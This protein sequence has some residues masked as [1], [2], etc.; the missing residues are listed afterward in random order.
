MIRISASLILLLALAVVHHTQADAGE[1][2]T[3]DVSKEL[4]SKMKFN[5]TNRDKKITWN[6]LVQLYDRKAA[7]I[8]LARQDR[9]PDKSLKKIEKEYADLMPQLEFLLADAN[10]DLELTEGELS[11]YLVLSAKG[12]SPKPELRHH[13]K[14]TSR[15]VQAHWQEIVM[16]MVGDSLFEGETASTFEVEDMHFEYTWPWP[17]TKAFEKAL[18]EADANG[19]GVFAQGEYARFKA[20]ERMAGWWVDE[21][22]Q[23]VSWRDE[24]GVVLA[25]STEAQVP[26]GWKKSNRKLKLGSSWDTRRVSGSR[27]GVPTWKSVRTEIIYLNGEWAE[28]ASQKARANLSAGDRFIFRDGAFWKDMDV[29]Q[30]HSYEPEDRGRDDEWGYHGYGSGSR[31]D[32]GFLADCELEE[33]VVPAGKL[34]C[35]RVVNGQHESYY[36][37]IDGISILA[38]YSSQD[39]RR[40]ELTTLPK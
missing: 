39:E 14:I 40:H 17:D 9:R 19:D 23:E 20:L 21:L 7:T 18:T 4:A 3:I 29:Y 13:E 10:E 25:S 32:L 33:I 30:T 8:S 11:D 37:V 36:Y 34:H 31:K 38:L 24:F 22:A 15:W 1:P 26:K 2:N 5:D 35:Y 16:A 12:Q 27:G 28:S 6:E